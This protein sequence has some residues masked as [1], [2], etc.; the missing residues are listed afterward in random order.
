MIREL[1]DS[2]YKHLKELLPAMQ[3]AYN[4]TEASAIGVSPF[5]AGH[6]FPATSVVAARTRAAKSGGATDPDIMEDVSSKFD[7]SVTKHILELAQ[8]MAQEARATS[9]WH[10]RMT[11]KMLNQA[12]KPLDLSKFKPGTSVYFY[13]PPTIHQVETRKRKA[14]HLD[15]YVGPGK[16][17][18]QI[19]ARS[20]VI[21]KPDGPDSSTPGKI[22]EFQRDIG[23]IIPE[24][25]PPKTDPDPYTHSVPEM[26]TCFHRSRTIPRTGEHI[27]LKD[28]VTSTD[29]YCAQVLSVLND[30][31]TV[32]YFTTEVQPLS[33]YPS[34]SVEERMANMRG[35]SYKRTWTTKDGN[36]ST[37]PPEKQIRQEKDMWTG[38]VSASHY[39]D[40]IL[41]RNVGLTSTGQLDN[42]TLALAAKLRLPHHRGP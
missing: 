20:F 34:S 33:S 3:F 4:T 38:L 36:A 24:K 37:V 1:S 6:G 14:K 35:A 10:R 26:G 19:G 29:W 12:G 16:V 31:L 22:R 28:D 2:E 8:V 25:L 23:M 21:E 42:K 5:Q 32:W 18:R 40:Q 11:N 15:H 9:E 30:R 7:K 41:L 27:I 39:D 13:K 17:K